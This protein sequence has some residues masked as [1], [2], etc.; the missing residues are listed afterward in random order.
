[1]FAT[2]N[3]TKITELTLGAN[4]ELSKLDRFEWMSEETNSVDDNNDEMPVTIIEDM[5]NVVMKP[6]EIRTFIID[7]KRN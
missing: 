3:I 7:I 4:L 2:F 6:S 1:M 5:I